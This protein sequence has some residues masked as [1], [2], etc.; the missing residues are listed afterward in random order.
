MAVIRDL[1]LAHGGAVRTPEEFDALLAEIKPK[2]AGEV[3]RI[4]VGIAPGLADFANMRAE[5]A[6]WEGPAIDD[7]RAQLD[8][9]LPK[10]AITLHGAG[11]LQHLPRYI[12]AM[13]IRLEDMSLDPDRD[14]DRQ[15]VIDDAKRYLAQK[16]ATLPANRKKSKAYKDI[17]WRIEELRVSIFAQRLGTP[18]PVSQ[19]RIEKM[20]DALR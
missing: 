1:L 15:M 19:R 2:V 3:R 7:M 14:A 20:T 5:L 4:V 9:Y 10:H 11:H 17:L 12:E 13:R 6:K 8:F 16:M 18:Q